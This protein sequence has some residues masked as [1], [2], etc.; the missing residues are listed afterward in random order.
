MPVSSLLHDE[1]L[2]VRRFQQITNSTSSNTH[3]LAVPQEGVQVWE[4]DAVPRV[5]G[6]GHEG[7]NSAAGAR[8]D[9]ADADGVQ[10]MLGVW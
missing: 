7:H 9:P 4:D 6:L 2:T 1:L 8:H 10:R 3:R 5:P